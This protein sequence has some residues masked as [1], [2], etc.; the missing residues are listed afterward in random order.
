LLAEKCKK[1]GHATEIFKNE[2]SGLRG[3]DREVYQEYLSFKKRM[4]SVLGSKSAESWG[5]S[6]REA[7][8]QER[9]NPRLQRYS[10]QRQ[11]VWDFTGGEKEEGRLTFEG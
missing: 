11:Q 10:H 6:Q 7:R 8:G 3:E 4:R 9:V 1:K 5:P 2:G